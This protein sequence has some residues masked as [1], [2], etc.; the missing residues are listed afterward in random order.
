MPLETFVTIET[1]AIVIFLLFVSYT[2]AHLI[3]YMESTVGNKKMP[4]IFP[5]DTNYF[6]YMPLFAGIMP[7]LIIIKHTVY[8]G[9]NGFTVFQG[10]MLG[11]DI[12]YTLVSL[13]A[14]RR[15]KL[16]KKIVKDYEELIEGTLKANRDLTIIN[17]DLYNRNQSLIGGEFID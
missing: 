13:L 2:A 12:T 16:Y 1:A 7:L 4:K 17:R 6:L 15:I 5:K 11:F 14:E 9:V 10:F 3:F 8:T